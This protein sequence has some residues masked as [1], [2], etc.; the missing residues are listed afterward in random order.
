MYVF[1]YGGHGSYFWPEKLQDLLNA[2][3]TSVKNYLEWTVPH[4][5]WLTFD[6]TWLSIVIN[7]CKDTSTW[8][9][10]CSHSTNTNFVWHNHD[11]LLTV[12][13][14]TRKIITDYHAL[15][16]ITHTTHG[17]C[18]QEG[19]QREIKKLW[20]IILMQLDCHFYVLVKYFVL[21]ILNICTLFLAQSDLTLRAMLK[22]NLLVAPCIP[23]CLSK[24][25]IFFIHPHFT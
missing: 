8:L 24:D 22:R 17:T 23:L 20:L 10:I 19:V 13:F 21:R 7:P 18:K 11:R 14:F 25:M 5:H 6:N 3:S 9:S 16:L 15:K 12:N 1:P 2:I 4:A